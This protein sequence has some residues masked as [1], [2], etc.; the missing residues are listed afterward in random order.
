Q[1]AAEVTAFMGDAGIEAFKT[2][3]V[4]SLRK[5]FAFV[6]VKQRQGLIEIKGAIVVFVQL[7][8]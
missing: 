3:K 7:F 8:E 5:S 1:R 2:S 4:N 6:Q